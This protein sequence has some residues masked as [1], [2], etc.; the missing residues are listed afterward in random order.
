MTTF[1]SRQIS[2]ELDV[3][4]PD[5]SEIRLVSVAMAAVSM[6]H[7]TLKPGGTT[8]AV[9]HVT[10][11]ETWLCISGEGRLW[12]SRDGVQ[13]TVDLVPGTGASIATGTRF[14]FTNDGS[15]P[16]EIVIATVPAWPGDDEAIECE[17]AWYPNV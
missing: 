7:C 10:V 4:A 11:A 13:E 6:V 17:G 16:L 5:G 14:Q 8:K 9:H 1:E 15:T 12:R 3:I 2:E